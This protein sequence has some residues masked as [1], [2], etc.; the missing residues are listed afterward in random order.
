MSRSSLDGMYGVFFR[1]SP[2]PTHTV[3]NPENS[4]TILEPR[5]TIGTQQRVQPIVLHTVL[6]SIA[7]TCLDDVIFNLIHTGEEGR[8]IIGRNWSVGGVRDAYLHILYS[9]H[10]LFMGENH[11]KM[12]AR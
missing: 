5:R 8:N 9:N 1:R 2:T 10:S 7:I 4:Q 3:L 11:N 6:K 12:L